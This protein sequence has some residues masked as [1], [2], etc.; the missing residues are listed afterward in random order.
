MAEAICRNCGAAKAD[1]SAVCERCGAGPGETRDEIVESLFLSVSRFG[2]RGRR[3]AYRVTLDDFASRLRAGDR[4]FFDPA[5][6]DRLTRELHALMDRTGRRPWL[7]LL[8]IFLPAILFLF[9]LAGLGLV[10]TLLNGP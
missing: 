7:T 4:S 3:D 9:G 5:E 2:D 1:G 6:L 10:L 8:R